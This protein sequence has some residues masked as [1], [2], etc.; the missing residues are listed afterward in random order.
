MK[1][2]ILLL[3]ASI[4]I[5]ACER[6]MVEPEFEEPLDLE[7]SELAH[8]NLAPKK[9]YVTVDFRG[10]Y[11][12]NPNKGD[13]DFFSKKAPKYSYET[14]RERFLRNMKVYTQGTLSMGNKDYKVVNIYNLNKHEI[15][16][17]KGAIVSGRT[18]GEFTIRLE[19]NS[20]IKEDEYR[21]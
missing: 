2:L 9:T 17:K 5:L 15:L 14:D 11:S 6:S 4:L 20:R 7:K 8:Q 13:G 1:N 19:D 18:W 3:T 10:Q 21:L 12:F 16:S